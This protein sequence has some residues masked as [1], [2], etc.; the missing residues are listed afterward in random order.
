MNTYDAHKIVRDVVSGEAEWV[1]INWRTYECTNRTNSPSGL[2]RR[3]RPRRPEGKGR[4]ASSQEQFLFYG[5]REIGGKAPGRATLHSHDV[6]GQRF[7]CDCDDRF[8][9][10]PEACKFCM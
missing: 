9:P 7:N 4:S 1:S 5:A 3:G 10:A 2:R 8:P 6:G